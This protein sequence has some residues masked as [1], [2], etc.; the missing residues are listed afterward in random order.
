MISL[1]A[2]TNF[3][4]NFYSQLVDWINEFNRTID[5]NFEVGVRLV[6]FG[7]TYVF[8]LLD[9]GFSNPSLIIF[10]GL[11]EQ[12]EPVQLIQHVNQISILLLKLPRKE[13]DKP[14][15]VFGFQVNR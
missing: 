12:N 7:Q 4:D 5:D 6:N 1:I 13:P 9:I 2:S 10:Y 15:K 11:T 14:K 8:H 3:A